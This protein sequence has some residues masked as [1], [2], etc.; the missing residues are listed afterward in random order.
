MP[1][2]SESERPARLLDDE[3]DREEL[4][5]RY[6]GLLQEL[7]VVLPGVQVLL[8]FLLTVPFAQRFEELGATDRAVFGAGLVCALCSVVA[9]LTPIAVH[10]VGPRT[11]RSER[12]QLGIVAT[13]VGLALLGLSILLSFAVVSNL[14]FNA[15]IMAVLVTFTTSAMLG[16]WLILPLVLRRERR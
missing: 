1:S 7:R 6:Q 2:T 16:M 3:D 4:R 8:A 9:F 14:L 12:L 11:E 5:D 13:R 15:V 10:R